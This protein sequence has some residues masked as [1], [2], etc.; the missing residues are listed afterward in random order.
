[1]KT[2]ALALIGAISMAAAPHVKAESVSLKVKAITVVSV[3][4]SRPKNDPKYTKNSILPLTVTS[5]IF[6]APKGVSIPITSKSSTTNVYFKSNGVLSTS[7]A[8]VHKSASTGKVISVDL[9]FVGPVPVFGSVTAPSQV[10]YT[11]VLK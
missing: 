10:T 8:T 2:I 9:A 7:T 6:K 1:M 4:T 5:A 3:S 11:L